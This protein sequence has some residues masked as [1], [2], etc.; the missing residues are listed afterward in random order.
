MVA[1]DVLTVSEGAEGDKVLRRLKFP[2]R[3]TRVWDG[4]MGYNRRKIFSYKDSADTFDS[5]TRGVRD[6]PNKTAA[7]LTTSAEVSYLL[8]ALLFIFSEC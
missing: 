2:D 6:L 3:H 4:A 8:H 5:M 7:R 1:L